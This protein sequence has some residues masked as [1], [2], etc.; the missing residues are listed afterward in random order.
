MA[1]LFVVPELYLVVV[2][3][4]RAWLMRFRAELHR[5]L[6]DY[7]IRME[8]LART[9]MLIE[10]TASWEGKMSRIILIDASNLEQNYQ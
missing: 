9:S 2:H 7:L 1:Q 3:E 5:R 4:S 10:R 8:L 6:E